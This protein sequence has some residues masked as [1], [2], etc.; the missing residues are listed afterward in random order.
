MVAK[1]TPEATDPAVYDAHHKTFSSSLLPSNSNEWIARAAEVA[2]ILAEDVTER[3]KVQRVPAAE[4]SLLKSSGLLRILG[5]TKFGGGG[6]PWD[7]GYKV[8][9]EVAKGDG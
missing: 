9:R 6:Q 8:I 4:V 2:K 3:D 7:V 5:P 1:I